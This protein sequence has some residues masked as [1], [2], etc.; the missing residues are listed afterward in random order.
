M[1]QQP[2]HPA[3][4]EPLAAEPQLRVASPADAA[5][6]V[7][8]IHAAF[9]ARPVLDPPSTAGQETEHSV[10]EALASGGGVLAEVNG[11]I[12]GVI[13]VAANGQG[14]AGRLVASWRRVSVHPDFWG[15]G[16]GTG[17]VAAAEEYAAEQGYGVV[18]LI[19]RREFPELLR[20]WQ[21]RGYRTLPA[22]PER[23]YNIHLSKQLP[24][25]CWVPT[26]DEMRELGRRL[27]PLLRAG[28]LVVA[29]GDLGAGKT[30]LTQGLGEGLGVTEPVT[31]PTFV[32]SRVHPSAAGGPPLVHVD[33]YRLGGLDELEDLDLDASLAEAVTVVEWGRGAAEGMSDHRLEID[34]LRSEDGSE[35]R[36]VLLRGVG[37]RW[38]DVDLGVVTSAVAHRSE[39]S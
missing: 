12:A 27:A 20:F 23:P 13:L 4:A 38:Q 28:D 1:I 16:I 25:A 18:E 5:E 29:S 11:R 24:A 19:A 30:T 14:R 15:H 31:S 26:A 35:P 17:L 9:G 6:L 3:A 32:L 39:R 10:R 21:R 36:L 2:S 33:A 37:D 34:V 22:D 8:V 7:E